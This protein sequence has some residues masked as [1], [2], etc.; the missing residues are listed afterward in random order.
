MVNHEVFIKL[1]KK[2]EVMDE[3]GKQ[4]LKRQAHSPAEKRISRL[5]STH[6]PLT[7]MQSLSRYA[8]SNNWHLKPRT[9]L[10]YLPI[11]KSTNKIIF[12]NLEIL[13]IKS[14]IFFHSGSV[15][16]Y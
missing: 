6:C 11:I 9:N 14:I 12:L 2:T 4:P 10:F 7:L 5:R 8:L 15:V 13:F 16:F 1:K 3:P